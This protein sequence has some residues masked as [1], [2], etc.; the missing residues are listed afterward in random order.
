MV[1]WIA[2]LIPISNKNKAYMAYKKIIITIVIILLVLLI[3]DAAIYFIFLRNQI[4]M[5]VNNNLNTVQT[6]PATPVITSEFKPS[7][8]LSG[9]YYSE[10]AIK[11]NSLAP[12]YK[13]QSLDK[14]QSCL[15]ELK[16]YFL[17]QSDN[18]EFCL[19]FL[20][21]EDQ[22]DCV[23]TFV[24]GRDESSQCEILST[25]QFKEK[26]REDYALNKTISGQTDFCSII[27]DIVV[28]S[29]CLDQAY[30]YD[31]INNGNTNSCNNINDSDLKEICL[32]GNY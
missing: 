24:L 28:K 4:P 30:F 15:N 32:N 22:Y 6:E 9:V 31:A 23:K 27:N 3:A 19:A 18:A 12:C 26:C 1:S 11:E 29:Q 2:S 5:S 25:D 20:L 10:Q 21:P 7:P 17:N 13:I 14:R 16:Q 8:A